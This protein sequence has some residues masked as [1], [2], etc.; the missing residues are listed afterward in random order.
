MASLPLLAW[1]AEFPTRSIEL[2][3][4][5]PPGGSSDA[6]ARAVA[7]TL[8]KQFGQPVVVVNKPG[9]GGIVA[10]TI[11]SKAK[12]D[13]YTILIASSTALVM[14][15][16]FEKVE[17]DALK[18]FTYLGLVARLIPMVLVRADSPW[19]TFEDL[20]TYAKS[21]PGKLRYGTSGPH[22]GT[23]VAMSAM[24]KERNLDWVHVPFKGDGP[25]VNA[26]LGGHIDVAGLFSVYKPHV[27]A[28]KLR[29]LVSLMDTRVKAFPDVPTYKELGFRFDT[30]GSVQSI[31]GIIAPAG[32][33]PEIVTRYEAA[34]K[35][36]VD[37]P[38]FQKTV[39]TAGM[40]SDFMAAP[41]YRREM[42]EGHH[43]AIR[44]VRELGLTK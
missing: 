7:P 13:G 3:V 8:E 4:P 18:D 28:G 16:R 40:V 41:A 12:P 2:V 22:S 30:K 11:V 35:A 10:A 24:A 25:V 31:T 42:E 1:S 37:S 36:A 9:A 5:Y 27:N 19:K 44:M 26:I 32:V 14:A 29:P 33:A 39:E 15:P 21:N 17:Y 43:N 20:A 38:E 6:L 34:L 23:H